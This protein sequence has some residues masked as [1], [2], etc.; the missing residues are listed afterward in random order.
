MVGKLAIV[1]G[2]VSNTAHANDNGT[3]DE[4]AVAKAVIVYMEVDKVGEVKF[5]QYDQQ[6]M[7]NY[8]VAP[9]EEQKVKLTSEAYLQINAFLVQNHE[10]SVPSQPV[11]PNQV[12]RDVTRQNQVWLNNALSTTWMRATII[13]YSVN[14]GIRSTGTS[15]AYWSPSAGVPDFITLQPTLCYGGWAISLSLPPSFQVTS[16]C[17]T[18][19]SQQFTNTNYASS[20]YNNAYAEGLGLNSVRQTDQPTVR[21]LGAEFRPISTVYINKS[22]S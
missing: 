2:L 15:S 16:D 14:L 7:T 18:Y 11:A 19:T 22:S 3:T 20:Q 4:S 1:F 10:K 12:Q 17:G 5:Y 13:Q 8:T 9:Q 21:R 6:G